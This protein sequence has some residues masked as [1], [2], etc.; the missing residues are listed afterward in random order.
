MNA[1]VT[2]M[3]SSNSS[4]VGFAE[5]EFGSITTRGWRIIKQSNGSLRV[6][7]PVTTTRKPDGRLF[8]RPLLSIP[9]E[10]EQEAILAIL[11]EWKKGNHDEHSKKS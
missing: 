9:P 5:V 11:T 7:A 1:K 4:L 6:D 2:P 8:Y 10:L 3:M